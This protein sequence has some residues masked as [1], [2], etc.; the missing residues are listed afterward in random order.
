MQI[1]FWFDSFHCYPIDLFQS[2]AVG[3]AS[4]GAASRCR[5]LAAVGGQQ[6]TSIRVRRYV[7]TPFPLLLLPLSLPLIINQHQSINSRRMSA[8][9]I[10]RRAAA[11][12]IGFRRL[13]RRRRRL[14]I[15]ARWRHWRQ[16]ESGT[17][18]YL[19]W[20]LFLAE[21]KKIYIQVK[22]KLKNFSNDEYVMNATT[23]HLTTFD[24]FISFIYL[25]IYL[26]TCL[27]IYLL[28]YSLS[29]LPTFIRVNLS[30]TTCNELVR[31]LTISSG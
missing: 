9:F 20:V 10:N 17:T 16:V 6:P 30:S 14:K 27:F 21:G 5:S 11:F 3:A 26:F 12:S 28:A 29:D 24:I 15:G 8:I 18:E 23:L 19:L 1:S 2:F 7:I 25:F 22:N 13:Q 4:R 31:F